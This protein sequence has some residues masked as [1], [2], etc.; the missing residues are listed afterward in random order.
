MLKAIRKQLLK[1]DCVKRKVE[2]YKSEQKK[3][4]RYERF[5]QFM[6]SGGEFERSR[7]TLAIVTDEGLTVEYMDG[8]MVGQRCVTP[9]FIDSTNWGGDNGRLHL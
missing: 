5:T 7:E 3:Q 2:A 1:F 4:Q 6:R 8:R 9:L